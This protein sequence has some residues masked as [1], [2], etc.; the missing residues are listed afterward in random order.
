MPSDAPAHGY[1][2]VVVANRLPVDVSLDD[3]GEPHLDPI[4]RR[5]GHGARAGDGEH[6]GAWVGWGGSPDLE[7]EPFDADGMRAGPGARC[8]EDDLEK[9]Y[10]GFS[11]DTLWPLYH[12]VIEPPA[13]HREWWDAYPKVN[14]RFARGGRRPGR[15]RARPCG[16]T[17]TSCS[18]SPRCC[19]SCGPTCASATSTTSPSRR[20]SCS[21]SCRGACQ[22]IEGLLGADLRRLPARPATPANF[23]RVG[24][25][26]HGPDD[27]AA[28]MVTLNE[29]RGGTRPAARARARRSR[30]RSTRKR[31]TSWPAPRG[32]RAR[33]AD[34]RASSATPRSCCSAS[35]GS[36]TPRAS[37]TGSRRTGSSCRT[38]GSSPQS[39]TL[40]QVASPSREH[41]EQYQQ[42]RDDVELPVGRINGDYG[43]VGH[44][45]VQYLHHIVPAWRRWRPCT[46]PPTSC[47]SRPCATA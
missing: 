14:R 46:S 17:T 35:T 2:F 42:L 23:V 40:V 32:P 24:A 4:P 19:A 8:R 7:L 22:V 39:T 18:W 43:S 11:N 25:P 47:S 41:V 38:A 37:G 30:S 21:R 15:R 33:P 9:F 36:T 12:D 44:A 5:P 31:S 1:D 13:F 20:W 27:R 28:Q 10:E 26:A 34:P 3:D 29:A 45:A 6:A 16:C